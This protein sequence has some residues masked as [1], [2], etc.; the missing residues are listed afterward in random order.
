MFELIINIYLLIGKNLQVSTILI[1]KMNTSLKKIKKNVAM[2]HTEIY[3]EIL[4]M[5]SLIIALNKFDVKNV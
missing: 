1:N 4:N 5:H 2:N 3:S